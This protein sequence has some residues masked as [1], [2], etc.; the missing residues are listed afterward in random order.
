LLEAR[1]LQRYA[2][3][4]R[5]PR[6]ALRRYL[7]LLPPASAP[8]ALPPAWW[9]IPWLAALFEP[10]PLLPKSQASREFQRRLFLVTLATELTPWGAEQTRAAARRSFAS[11]AVRAIGCGIVELGLVPWRIAV[12]RLTWWPLRARR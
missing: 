5:A 3:G 7:R 8:L 9:R 11:F 6:F 12:H 4:R 10:V 2:C 1:A